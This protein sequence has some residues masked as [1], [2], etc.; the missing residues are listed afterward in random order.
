M[1]GQRPRIAQPR[2]PLELADAVVVAA[3]AR[4]GEAGSASLHLGALHVD[5]GSGHGLLERLDDPADVRA[6]APYDLA[7]APW[8]ICAA[9]C[10][11]CWRATSPA[12]GTSS[13]RTLSRVGSERETVTGSVSPG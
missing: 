10:S 9:S 1:V 2:Q 12:S 4:G 5:L 11:A 6:A 3:L 7:A 8:F 13:Q